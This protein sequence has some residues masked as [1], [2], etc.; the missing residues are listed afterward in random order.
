M[1]EGW[2]NWRTSAAKEILLE[3]LRPGA[4]LYEEEDSDP[5]IIYSIYKHSHEEFELVPFEQFAARLG[6]NNPR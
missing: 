5:A 2:I 3:D 6:A 1:P 4:W